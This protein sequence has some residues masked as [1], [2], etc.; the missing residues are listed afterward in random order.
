MRRLH[1]ITDQ[2]GFTM[3]EMIVVTLI[4]SVLV[5]LALPIFNNQSDKAKNTDV[6]EKIAQAGKLAASEWTS[7]DQSFASQATVVANMQTSAPGIS[8]A[9]GSSFTA[10][11]ISVQITGTHSVTL[12]GVSA[13]GVDYAQRMIMRGPGSGTYRTQGTSTVPVVNGVSGP[14]FEV[15]VAPWVANA[16]G[17]TLTK[18]D[19]YA[20]SGKSSLRVVTSGGVDYQGAADPP[21]GQPVSADTQYRIGAYVRAAESSSGRSVCLFYDAVSAGGATLNSQAQCQALTTSWQRVSLNVTTPATTTAARVGVFVDSSDNAAADFYVDAV[22]MTEG[23]TSYPYF[24]GDYPGGSWTG[25][26]QA[27]PSSALAWDEW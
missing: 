1:V 27:S 19:T 8:L 15:G 20:Y 5:A 13:S 10:G 16:G 7:N 22:S 3:I 23:S 24:D 26:A 11:Q 4:L 14:S 2:A 6:K 17:S 25:A 12:R 9:G 18:S 21:A